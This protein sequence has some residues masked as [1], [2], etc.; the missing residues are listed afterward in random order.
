MDATEAQELALKEA[1]SKY[2]TIQD[3]SGA[4]RDMLRF[5]W[6]AETLAGQHKM[7]IRSW[8]SNQKRCPYLQAD[9]ARIAAQIPDRMMP[10]VQPAVLELIS[11]KK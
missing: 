5:K 2:P 11:P 4:S 9:V 10:K 3:R 7:R 8:P 6:S 1:L